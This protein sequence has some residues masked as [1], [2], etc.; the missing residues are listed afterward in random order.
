[1]NDTKVN[2]RSDAE[3]EREALDMLARPERN[4]AVGLRPLSVVPGFY[5]EVAALYA[6]TLWAGM[7]IYQIVREHRG[8]LGE[9]SGIASIAT[10]VFGW[11]CSVAFLYSALVARRISRQIDIDND[12]RMP[13]L[14]AQVTGS[15]SVDS[16]GER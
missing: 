15:V 12:E 11:F 14:R 16:Q 5:L 1:M 13:Q 10:V 7:L 2:D 4:R 3:D 6:S 8:S 9:M